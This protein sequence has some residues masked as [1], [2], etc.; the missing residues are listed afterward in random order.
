MFEAGFTKV[1]CAGVDL[2]KWSVGFAMNPSTPHNKASD[3]HR[4]NQE[5]DLIAGDQNPR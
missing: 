5:V 4:V 1:L 3:T 2:G